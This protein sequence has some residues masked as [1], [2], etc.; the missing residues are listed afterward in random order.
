MQRTFI[1]LC[2][3]S[4]CPQ[5]HVL[6]DIRHLENTAAQ[7]L[8]EKGG[9]FICLTDDYGGSVILTKQQFDSLKDQYDADDVLATV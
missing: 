4:C 2:T 3:N 1:A 8:L 7:E 6:D 5:L 9:P